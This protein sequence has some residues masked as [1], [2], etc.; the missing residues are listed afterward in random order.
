[1]PSSHKEPSSRRATSKSP[2][3]SGANDLVSNVDDSSRPVRRRQTTH[4]PFAFN[5]SPHFE[6]TVTADAG[7]VAMASFSPSCEH[8]QYL[9][10]F[11]IHFCFGLHSSAHLSAQNFTVTCSEASD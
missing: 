7:D 3:T 5:G 1:R 4:S 9:V 11:F 10:Q 8:T 6:Q 2:R